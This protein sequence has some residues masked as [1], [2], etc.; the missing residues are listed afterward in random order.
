MLRKSAITAALLASVSSLTANATDLPSSKSATA[1]PATSFANWTGV[2][3]GMNAGRAWNVFDTKHDWLIALENAS[4]VKDNVI[5]SR[6]NSNKIHLSG[7]GQAGYNHQIERGVIGIEADFNTS[8]FGGTTLLRGGTADQCGVCVV[9]NSSKAEAKW[10]GTVRAR[11]GYALGSVL[12]YGTGGLA[13]GGVKGSA[14]WS[15]ASV[16]NQGDSA[17]ALSTRSST[18]W[19]W[20]LGVGGEYAMDLRWSVKAEYLHYNL[21]SVT[22]ASIPN[23]AA[24]ALDSPNPIATTNFS[25]SGD[26]VRVGL[27]HRF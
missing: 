3:G 22:V 2:Y 17:A 25:I 14:T 10:L 12:F 6:I 15:I 23:A 7:G 27:N 19:G 16:S 18:R 21:G 4:L 24:I 8:Q 20:T 9:T 26:L 1:A 11:L 13:Y 5:L